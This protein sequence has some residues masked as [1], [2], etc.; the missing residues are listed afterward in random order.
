[1][2]EET[3]GIV[4]LCVTATVVSLATHAFIRRSD[5][6]TVVSATVATIVFQVFAY[7]Y[8]GHLDKFF[9]IAVVVG[10][11]WCFAIAYV[12]GVP[13]RIARKPRGDRH[14]RKCGYDLTGNVS[15][16]CPECGEAI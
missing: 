14:C 6:A 5:L 9:L 7:I 4:V 3:T 10:W 13:F 16:V 11:C 2:S 8:T 15:G 12:V 1:M